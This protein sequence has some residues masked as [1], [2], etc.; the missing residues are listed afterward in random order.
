MTKAHKGETQIRQDIKEI[1]K[2]LP[3]VD[4]PGE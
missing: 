2:Y 1:I 3:R 4:A